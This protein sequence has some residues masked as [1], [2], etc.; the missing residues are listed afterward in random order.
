MAPS[1]GAAPSYYDLLLQNMRL[2]AALAGG[3][4][5]GGKEKAL[6]D[7][8]EPSYDPESFESMLF[9]SEANYRMEWTVRGVD[10]IILCSQACSEALVAYGKQWT[11]WIHFAVYQPAFEEEHAWFWSPKFGKGRLDGQDPAWLAVYFAYCCV[12]TSLAFPRSCYSDAS[13]WS[14][15]PPLRRQWSRSRACS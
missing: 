1:T 2:R 12:S 9:R 14:P 4:P 11:Y 15:C 10:D 13:T 6:G 3:P 5:A 8:V 7:L